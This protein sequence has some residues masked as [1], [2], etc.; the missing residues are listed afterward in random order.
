MEQDYILNTCSKIL[1]IEFVIIVVYF[2]A[3]C[4]ELYISRYIIA[5]G[6][7]RHLQMSITVLLAALCA[8]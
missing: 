6:F 3:G 5:K 1:W 2:L 4:V 8:I 7:H